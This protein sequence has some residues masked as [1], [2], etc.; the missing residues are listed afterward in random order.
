MNTQ[1]NLKSAM[2]KAQNFVNGTWREGGSG[3]LDMIN[4]S[5]DSKIGEIARS[6]KKDV[7]DAVS[8]ARNAFNGEWGKT[9]AALNEKKDSRLCTI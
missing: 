1:S 5:Y 7:D 3:T 2:A 8:A 9:E 6:S 4:P